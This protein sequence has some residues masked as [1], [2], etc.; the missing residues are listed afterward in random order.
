MDHNAQQYLPD[1][2][3]LEQEELLNVSGCSILLISRRRG[4][5]DVAGVLGHVRTRPECYCV[6]SDLQCVVEI[7]Y[8]KRIKGV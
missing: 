1:L 2:L 8:Q 5:E 6:M 3:A 4:A 7:F